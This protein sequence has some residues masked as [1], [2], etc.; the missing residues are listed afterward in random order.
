MLK[1]VKVPAKFE[2][3]FAKAEINVSRFFE[4]RETNIS[5]A[6]IKIAG[7]RYLLVRASSLSVDFFECVMSLYRD[8]DRKAALQT[9]QQLLF[10]ISHAIGMKDA[11]HFHK[12]MNLKDPID[13]LAA[14]P[15]HFAYTGW[16]KV[17]IDPNS[18]PTPDEN[19][20]IYYD[21][22]YSFEADSW[23]KSGKKSDFPVC[24][25]NAGYSSGWSEQSYNVPLVAVEL[26][27]RAKGDDNCHFI[28]AHVNHIEEHIEK[29][30]KNKPELK[31]KSKFEIPT[32]FKVKKA[33][34]ALVEANKKLIETNQEL[35]AKSEALLQK[36]HLIE[37]LSELG[38][39]LPAC[40]KYDEVYEVFSNY[41]QKLFPNFSGQLFLFTNG[42]CS[43]ECVSCWGEK[44]SQTNLSF[45]PQDCWA[46]LQNQ[47]YT[48]QETKPK[49]RCN[50][51]LSKGGYICIP[52]IVGNE[53][54]GLI[55]LTFDKE[56]L[57]YEEVTILARLASDLGITI[58]NIRLRE[59]LH[60]LSIRD[61]LTGLY[62]RRY[63][64]E[65]LQNEI[66]KAKRTDSRFGLIMFDIDNYKKFND[67]YG[68]EAGDVVLTSLGQFLRDHFRES[69]IICRFG[70]EEFIIILREANEAETFEKA[71]LLRN[72][73]KKLPIKFGNQTLQELNISIGISVYPN[74]GK[75]GKDIIEAA[76][77]ALY[78]AKKE[79]RDR[80]C[81]ANSTYL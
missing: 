18:S 70:G 35:L 32:F 5:E 75:I 15:I 51:I 10:D 25:M 33:E 12:Y 52:I 13:K 47:V 73:V 19:Y 27:C 31:R 44:G 4:D 2:D 69:D 53:T 28:M 67:T 37:T 62:N 24:I 23:I 72:S 41:S 63:M 80:L 79:G 56:K 26:T 68:H 36:T 7:E 65:M 38:E 58:S 55:T 20:V 64:E 77:E 71:E 45:S 66:I 61:Y 14:G 9:T 76:D 42:K 17:N 54:I 60:E 1:T 11:E 48:V 30:L 22:P 39:L 43:L 21:H 34:A 8:K 57:S 16:A 6:T 78:R 59:S 49:P 40:T 74:H 29:Y 81:V 50:H 3:V 46:L